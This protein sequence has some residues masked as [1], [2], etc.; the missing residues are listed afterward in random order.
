[1]KLSI[2]IVNYNTEMFIVEL[3]NSI[4]QQEI[5]FNLIEVIIVNNVQNEILNESIAAQHYPFFVSIIQ[6]G[7]NV[8]FG[9]ANNLGAQRARG[10]Y[11]LILNPDITLTNRY[12]LSNFIECAELNPQ[13]GILSTR[14]THPNKVDPGVY[15]DY[16][17]GKHLGIEQNKIHWVIGALM[18]MK[19]DLYNKINGFDS[20]FFMY[21]EDADLCLR[22]LKYGSSIYQIQNLEVSHY[23]GAS[24]NK[25][26]YDYFVRWYRGLYLFCYKH[27]SQEV[28]NQILKNDLRKS[29]INKVRLWLQIRVL[30]FHNKRSKYMRWMAM[31]DCVKRTIKSPEWLSFKG[32]HFE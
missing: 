31:E 29:R 32:V 13:Y 21:F 8:G 22:V 18:L 17:Y 7:K 2:I 9:C 27:Y 19:R 20:D 16:P 14:I 15:Y 12:Y 3:L 11:L 30:F 24:E 5:D 4:A 26:S 28:F 10:Y 23:S 6:S 25:S 1:M